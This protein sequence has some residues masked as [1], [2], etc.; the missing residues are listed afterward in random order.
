LS[1]SD[2]VEH[3]PLAVGQIGKRPERRPVARRLEEPNQPLGDTRIVERLSVRDRMDRPQE[4]GLTGALQ[5]VA[6]GARA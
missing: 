2:Q 5:D 6:S 4:L 1:P 3:L